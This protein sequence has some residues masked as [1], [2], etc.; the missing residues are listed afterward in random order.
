[1]HQFENLPQ[2]ESALKME[3]QTSENF[4]HRVLYDFEAD[5]YCAT[6]N[7]DEPD[8]EKYLTVKKHEMVVSDGV[9]SDKWV[10]ITNEF[11][12]TGKIPFSYIEPI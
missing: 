6:Y 5:R 12:K 3:N 2:S 7:L 4:T 10:N 11:G 8:V 1:M 9:E